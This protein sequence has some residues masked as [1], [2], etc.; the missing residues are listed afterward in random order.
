M[1][2]FRTFSVEGCWGQPRLLFWKLV[3][4]T[5]I[6]KPLQLIRHQ[7]SKKYWSFYPSELNYFSHFSMRYPVLTIPSD[8]SVEIYL[9]N[10]FFILVCSTWFD[11]GLDSFLLRNNFYQQVPY[12]LIEDPRELFFQLSFIQRS[13]K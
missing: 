12:F 6:S 10:L 13:S 8:L 1:L 3:D 5:Q 2:N 7:N 11:D 9:Q 4:E